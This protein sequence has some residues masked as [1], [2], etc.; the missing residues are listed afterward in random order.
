[1]RTLPALLLAASFSVAFSASARTDILINVDKSTQQMTVRQDGQL[2]YTWPVSTGK[3][4]HATPS[5]D[6][7]AFRME[8]DH[9][10]KEWDDAPMPYSIFFT[11]VGHAIHGTYNKNLGLPVSHG[12]VRLSVAHAQKL[13][14]MVQ[15]EG[16]LKTKVVLTG[17]EQV[18]LKNHKLMMAAREKNPQAAQ[19]QPRTDNQQAR[20]QPA[21]PQAQPEPQYPQEPR[22]GYGAREYPAPE[23]AP[24]HYDQQ[25]YADRRY[26][27]TPRYDY[28][29]YNYG[30]REYRPHP[31]YMQPQYPPPQAYDPYRIRG[32]Y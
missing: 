2:L 17:S 21:D 25:Q 8:A 31:Q 9:F 23:Y 15:K 18:A 6:Y 28:P 5:G 22:Y 26:Y 11:K 27:G 3:T 24:P 7:R 14:A 20:Q 16:V 12:C 32:I 19:P 29:N 30:E 13:Y 10:S 4:G 1:M